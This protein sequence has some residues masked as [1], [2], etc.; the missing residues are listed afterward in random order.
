MAQFH[1]MPYNKLLILAQAGQIVPGDVYMAND[2]AQLY[3]AAT[4]GSIVPMA[5][6]I[7]SGIIS[8]E[9][10]APGPQ[11]PQGPAGA[12]GSTGSTGATGATGP[13]GPQGPPTP[14]AQQ[15]ALTI[16]LG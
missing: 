4:D 6:L 5:S 3:L 11:G 15:I 7:F 16:A 2:T 12:T 1:S 14:L 10:G 8:G 9:A 13:A